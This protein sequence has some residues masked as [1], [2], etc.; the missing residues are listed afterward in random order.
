MESYFQ[1][2][3]GKCGKKMGKLAV[4]LVV[5]A[6]LG[7]YGM[8][9]YGPIGLYSGLISYNMSGQKNKKI[10][11]KSPCILYYRGSSCIEGSC[12]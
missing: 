3:F 5:T 8:V 4:V 9:G 12:R 2:Q 10:K 1:T 7:K 6:G 11:R